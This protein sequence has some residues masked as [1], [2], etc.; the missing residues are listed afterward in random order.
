LSPLAL[1]P[2]LAFRRR[3]T[4]TFRTLATLILC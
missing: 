4:G 2:L 3:T 1:L